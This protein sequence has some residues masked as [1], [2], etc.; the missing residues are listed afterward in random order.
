MSL[1][2][3]DCISMNALF[4]MFNMYW[5]VDV[6]FGMIIVY[7][8]RHVFCHSQDFEISRAVC[9]QFLKSQFL[10]PPGFINKCYQM[11]KVNFEM[12]FVKW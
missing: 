2:L 5:C 9:K 1:C 3:R 8:Q 4:N 6:L 10:I 12:L 11:K 7:S